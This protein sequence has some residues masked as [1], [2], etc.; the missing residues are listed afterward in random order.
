MKSYGLALSGG[1]FRAS[2]FHL[3]VIR[4]MRD[5]GLL[6]QISHI[7][8]VSGGSIIAAHLVLNW[9]RY[10]GTDEAF[11]EVSGE[12]LRFLQMDV[13]N[14][15]VRRFPLT[16]FANFGRRVLR[17]GTR[18]QYT[19]AGLLEQHYEKYLYGDT[20]LFNLP[21]SPR[22]YI[23]A[24]NVNEGSISAF[25]RDG[26]LLQKRGP[27]GQKRFEQVSIG[28][29]TVSMAVAASS[30]FP[31]FFPPLDLKACDV[32]ASEGD[33]GR[34]AFTDGG[35]Y[36]NIGLRMFHHIQHSS[37]PSETDDALEG[38][39]QPN[40]FDGIFVS[41]A[42]ATFKVRPNR[43]AGGL[44]STAMRSS[45][46]LMDR[47]NQLELESFR[48]TDNAL[49]FPITDVIPQ[50][51][52]PYAPHEVIQRNA[53][54]IRT[55]MDRFTDLEISALVQHGYCVAREA[56]RSETPDLVPDCPTGPPWNPI[57]ESTAQVA[58]LYR[59]ENALAAAR[60]LQQSASRRIFRNLVN[61]RDWP[62]YVLVPLIA[63]M[64][65]SVPYL[66]YTA[67]KTAIQRGY[68]I[69]AVAAT[70]PVYRK[71][72][73]LIEDGPTAPIK[74]SAYEDVATMEK[75]DFSGFEVLSD[76]RIFDLRGWTSNAAGHESAPYMHSRINVRRSL[77]GEHNS[78]LRLQST[79]A[80]DTLFFACRT[81]SLKPRYKRMKQPDGKYI[82]E[83]DLDFSHIPLGSD[84][85]VVFEGLLISE[86]AQQSA[87]EGRF[88]FTISL[89]TGL[90]QIWILM[91][92]D[93][94]YDEF[95]ISGYPVGQPDLLQTIVP[96][97]TVELPIGS[98]ATF[99]LI[100]PKHD[101][102]YECR[103]KWSENTR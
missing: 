75:P 58:S 22:L 60:Q 2:L 12:L 39:S 102:S 33:F 97:S 73:S 83:A 81:D 90:A 48:G 3:G 17:L 100:N 51:R 27:H 36:D 42:G 16:T 21:A 64:L 54:L 85:E 24:T 35:I 26:V 72:L 80:D 23:L 18:R 47:V 59:E 68:V 56:C 55:D 95:E 30:A 63:A 53:A 87:D 28:L 14:R 91:P 94:T 1:G 50:S 45:D 71:I 82:W 98:I 52:D 49:F 40:Q 76:N 69:S 25:Y 6:S 13:R 74:P 70:S 103:W 88:Q 79:T 31:G 84:T 62:T 37:I 5:A 29:A 89:D 20:G 99:Q 8:S 66:L 43:A 61:L 32:G 65:L 96:T 38:P 78:H 86:Y 101:Y 19:R 77:D 34:M 10:C 11:Q 92:Q 46:I 4:F 57:D 7:T 9:D 67:N 15:I 93:H 44:L 41:N